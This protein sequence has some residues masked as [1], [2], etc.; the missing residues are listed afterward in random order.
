M[1]IDEFCSSIDGLS[2]G[3]AKLCELYTDHISVIGK[4]A[5]IGI[6][7]CQWQFRHSQWNCST[8]SNQTVFGPTITSLA[9]RE[10]AFV[11]AISAAG[12][13]QAISR[14]CRNG[15]ISTCGCSTSK[16]PENL[17]RDWVWGGCGDNIEYG[18]KFAK[19]FIDITEK[20][21]RDDRYSLVS[22]SNVEL[23]RKH[24]RN[25]PN[26]LRM[27]DHYRRSYE[28]RL[29][30]MEQQQQQSSNSYNNN[31]FKRNSVRDLRKIKARRLVNLHNNEAGR[32]VRIFSSF[33]F[34][35]IFSIAYFYL[36]GHFRFCFF[37]YLFFKGRLSNGQNRMQMSRRLRLVQ[38]ED[39]LAQVAFV[40]RGRRLFE[41]EIR[42]RH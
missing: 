15:D 4:G 13:L 35:S 8:V 30:I 42:Q 10:S 41:R 19:A 37:F 38:H 5:K 1:S 34:F 28:K 11:H 39:V 7:E 9:S 2:V 21:L 40:S 32:R 6:V 14:A 33:S 24:K 3:Q 36:I 16:R 17:N 23:T 22:N 12:A 26:N 31:L 20:S 29:A 25:N 27:L 18:Y